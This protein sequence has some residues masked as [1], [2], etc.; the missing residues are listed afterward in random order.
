MH[1]LCPAGDEGRGENA[2]QTLSK[3]SLTPGA[4]NFQSSH[5]A[6]RKSDP[7]IRISG[8]QDR[9]STDTRS[10]EGEKTEWNGGKAATAKCA[11]GMYVFLG[12]CRFCAWMG[13]VTEW[14]WGQDGAQSC[15]FFFFFKVGRVDWLTVSSLWATRGLN[16]LYFS[17]MLPQTEK[18]VSFKKKKK[19]T[20]TKLQADLKRYKKLLFTLNKQCL[21]CIYMSFFCRTGFGGAV[22]VSA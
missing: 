16:F 5:S 9:G 18:V 3:T 1:K 4:S 8:L 19:K 6:E 7:L 2:T 21:F 17:H 10:S 20:L 11:A 15:F 22:G 14:W 13:R 12:G